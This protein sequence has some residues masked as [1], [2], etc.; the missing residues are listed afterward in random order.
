MVQEFGDLATV[1]DVITRKRSNL[2][3]N[4]HLLLSP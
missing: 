4:V 1:E 3:P 2:Q